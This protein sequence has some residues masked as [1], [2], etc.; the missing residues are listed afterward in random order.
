MRSP[1]GQWKIFPLE[2][3]LCGYP[4]VSETPLRS[5]PSQLSSGSIKENGRM[6]DA[7]GKNTQKICEIDVQN[8]M[9]RIRYNFCHEILNPKL[10]RN[11]EEKFVDVLDKNF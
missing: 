6:G 8:Q 10:D 11:Y 4:Q 5:S 7:D 2:E 1:P 9:C 3:D